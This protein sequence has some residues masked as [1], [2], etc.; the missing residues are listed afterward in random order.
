MTLLIDRKTL[1]NLI[2]TGN[3]REFQ[4]FYQKYTELVGLTDVLTDSGAPTAQADRHQWYLDTSANVYYRNVDGGTTWEALG[5][6]ATAIPII[7]VGVN[8][9]QS[10]DS[11]TDTAIS[12]N[13]E[14]IK[15]SVFTHSTT[16]NPSRITVGSTGRYKVSGFISI[17]STTGNYRYTAQCAVR[18]DGTT[19]RQYID[20]SYLRNASGSNEASITVHDV[21]DL[22]A[23]Q[24]IEV[25]VA[26]INTTSGNGV[27]TVDRTK[28]MVERIA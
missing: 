13:T 4:N 22:T 26:R 17:N 27:T 7:S 28:V 25:M 24:Y 14:D 1:R 20:S 15:D 9:A 6:G 23:G 19:T 8:T 3:E 12:F 2:S 5:A 11:L 21:M 16:T 10:V 18:I